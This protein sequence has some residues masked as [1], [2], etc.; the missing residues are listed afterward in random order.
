MVKLLTDPIGATFAALADPTRRTLLERV[1]RSEASMTTLAAPTGLSLPAV[2]KHL[3]ALED[4]GLIAGEKRGRVR[5]YQLRPE[6]LR[7]ASTWLAH[8]RPFW[9]GQL[10]ALARYVEEKE[11]ETVYER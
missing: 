11:K 1:A 2:A 5:W 3:R 4:A 9:E 7:D 10:D 6:P 8:Y